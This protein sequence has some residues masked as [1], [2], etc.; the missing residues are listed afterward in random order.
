MGDDERPTDQRATNV[1]ITTAVTLML[2]LTV[3]AVLAA[4]F[5]F[6]LYSLDIA[7]D[8]DAAVFRD[9]GT[10]LT[11]I[12]LV[13]IL[14]YGLAGVCNAYLHSRRRFFASAWSPIAS[15]ICAPQYDDSVEMPIFAST[16]SNPFSTA[17]R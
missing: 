13:Q 5:I 15:N 12:F 8:V 16:L 3:L 2:A 11:R 17:A 6:R 9:V 14:F 4:P 7:A 10:T 1:I